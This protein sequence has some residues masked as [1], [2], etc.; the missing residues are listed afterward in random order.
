[1]ARRKAHGGGHGA[2][3][4]ADERWLIT[5]ADMIT[6]LLAVFIVMYALSD[7][8]LRKFNAFAQSMASIFN[9][10]VFTGSTAFT[11]TTGEQSAPDTQQMDS[12]SGF[13][14]SQ[15]RTIEAVVDDYAIRQGLGEDV[16]VEQVPEGVAIRIRSNLLFQPGRAALEDRSVGLLGEIAATVA[17]IHQDLRIVGHTDDTPTSG[18]LYADN[19]ELSTARAMAVLR[20]L[21]TAGID[22]ARLRVEGDGEYQPLVPNDSEADRAQNRRV[23]ILVLYPASGSAPDKGADPGAAPSLD[24]LVPASL[25]PV[26]GDQP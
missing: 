19:F 9:T 21:A 25:N 18:A 10:D 1:M 4:H 11:V 6:L 13:V 12:G 7:T 8:N 17:P 22:Q 3:I 20:F 15:A 2:E 14:A 26:F 5:Y 23:D 24:P 16:S